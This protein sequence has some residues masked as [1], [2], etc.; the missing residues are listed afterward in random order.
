MSG[1]YGLMGNITVIFVNFVDIY[2]HTIGLVIADTTIK[3]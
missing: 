1:S 3:I 2:Y